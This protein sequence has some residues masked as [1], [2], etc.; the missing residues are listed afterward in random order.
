MRYDGLSLVMRKT[1]EETGQVKTKK[2]LTKLI[3][4]FMIWPDN[5]GPDGRERA[6]T[7]RQVS[8]L[9]TQSFFGFLWKTIFAGMQDIMMR[10]GRYE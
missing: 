5:P 8:R 2:F 10:S 7:N 4:R 1:D 3:N 6:A 9:T